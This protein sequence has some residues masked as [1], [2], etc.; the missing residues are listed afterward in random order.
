MTKLVEV[1]L[2]LLSISFPFPLPLLFP[3]PFGVAAAG[4]RRSIAPCSSMRSWLY[5]FITFGVDIRRF[6]PARTFPL[7]LELPLPSAFKLDV[8]NNPNPSPEEEDGESDEY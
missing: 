7:P 3:D 1:D 5:L 6:S 2:A 8:F 4:G